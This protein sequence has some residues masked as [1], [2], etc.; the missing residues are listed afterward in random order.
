MYSNNANRY[1]LVNSFTRFL[2]SS[3]T[4]NIHNSKDVFFLYNKMCYHLLHGG[5]EVAVALVG[6]YLV[7]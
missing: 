6:D 1:I 2:N 7:A 4:E 3:S 5:V